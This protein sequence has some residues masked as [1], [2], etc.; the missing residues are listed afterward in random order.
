M[1]SR[2]TNHRIMAVMAA[3]LASIFALTPHVACAQVALLPV[4]RDL[5][6]LIGAVDDSVRGGRLIGALVTVVGTTRQAVT[7]ANGIFIIDSIPPGEHRIA[8]AHP[9][10]DTLGLEIVSAPVNLPAGSRREVSAHT[11]TFEEVRAK[12]CARGPVSGG[13]SILVGRVIQA[14]KDEPATGATVSLLFKDLSQATP[15]DKVRT[16]RVGPT[17]AFAICGLPGTLAG[18]LQATLGGV[19]TADLPVKTADASITTA[20]LSIGGTGAGNAVLTGRVIAR[21][22]GPIAGAQ[23]TVVGTTTVVTTRDD[24]T[25]TLAGLPSGTHEAVVRKIGFAKLSEIVH[26]TAATP[27]TLNV[28]LDQA[29]VLATIHVMGVMET[30]LTKIGFMQRK[31]HGMG[32]YITP[33]QIAERN[34][35][36]TTDLLRSMNGMRVLNAA[37]GRYLVSN[38]TVGSTTEGCITVFIDHARF[39]QYQPGDVDDAIPTGDLGAIEYYSTPATVPPEFA[40]PTKQCATLVVWTK[41]LLTT[42]KP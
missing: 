28:V 6:S 15:V 17:G 7:D 3:V 27:G 34:P 37:N 1:I 21:G 29:T 42:L 30:G 26:L 40:V 38:S 19:T 32:S 13:T 2:V 25:F 22:A 10:L 16:G 39:D 5:A 11:P 33:E 31:Q 18:N 14:D 8:V 9:M 36:Q 35:N 24:G 41:T 12:A 4:P 20:I 23:V